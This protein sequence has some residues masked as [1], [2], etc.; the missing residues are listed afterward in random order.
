MKTLTNPR[1]SISS[2][3]EQNKLS[4]IIGNHSFVERLR[5]SFFST[6]ILALY[7][8]FLLSITLTQAAT[9][10][11][12]QNG[13]WGSSSTWDRNGVPDVNNWPNDKV[14]INHA[15]SGGGVTMN[16]SSS[17]ITINNGGSLTL[18]G[19][20]N[21]GSGQVHVKSGGALTA[22]NI[23]LNTTGSCDLSGT[24]TTT[25]HMDLDGVFT[26]SPTIIVGGR[27]LAGA[28]NY[29]QIFTNLTLTVSG[30][31]TV[32]NANLRWSS[33]SVTVGGNFVLMG[34]GDVDVP[35]GGTLDVSGTLSVNDLLSIDGPSG[36]GSGGVVSWGVG[37]VILSGNNLG[38]NKCPKPYNSPF[39]LKTCTQALGSDDT[40]PVITLLGDNPA[41]VLV[42]SSYT[43]AGATAL[44]ETDGD[45]T[46]SI[47]TANNVDVNTIGTY[48]VTYDVSDAAGNAAT[49]ITRTVNVIDDI[50][51]TITMLGNNPESVE[52]GYTYSDAGAS[53]SDNYDGDITADIITTNSVDVTAVGT[54]SVT[55][56]VDDASGNSANESR[57][58]TV[59]P[60]VTAPVLT[61][62]GNATENVEMGST[63]TDA[64]ATVSDLG[65]PSIGVSDDAA[66]VNTNIVG[67]YTVTY[68]ATDASGNEST[69]TR[70][71]IVGNNSLRELSINQDGWH[72]LSF[73]CESIAL[74]DVSGLIATT[75]YVLLYDE[76]SISSNISEHSDDAW[77]QVAAGDFAT[78][79]VSKGD[80]VAVY[81]RGETTISYT[82]AEPLTD[83]PVSLIN[84]CASDPECDPGTYD[85]CPAQ[86]WNL[87]GNPYDTIV[88]WDQLDVFGPGMANAIYFWDPANSR[89]AAYVNGASVN[90]GSPY[91]AKGQGFFVYSANNNS[92]E[93]VFADYMKSNQSSSFYRLAMSDEI[94]ISL[95]GTSNTVIRS[96][97]LATDEF[98]MEFDAFELNSPER[99]NLISTRHGNV[100]FS[101]NTMSNLTLEDINL[102]FNVITSGNHEISM[103]SVSGMDV[104][105]IDNHEDVV[106]DLSSSSYRFVTEEGMNTN[107]FKLRVV[108]TEEVSGVS[109]DNV[110]AISFI[111]NPATDNIRV[112]SSEYINQLCLYNVQGD[113]I[114][115]HSVNDRE[116]NLNI[117]NLSKG[118]YTIRVSSNSV[119][120]S[121]VIVK[122]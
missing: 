106:H 122:L 15:V 63:Y 7:C 75:G 22:Y 72:Y 74:S 13:P 116:Y 17:R 54:Y 65:D 29:N 44:D 101:V 86:G 73:S 92:N 77:T 85:V 39:D 94:S 112:V 21:V 1:L 14:I 38:L 83:V 62:L 110:K 19:T 93:L 98:D 11:S 34:S 91:I 117:S 3:T 16:G 99:T 121:E 37:N 25:N 45:V 64:G 53:V 88:D 46:G 57:T 108:K 18:T 79:T 35:E 36:P 78:T 103:S 8:F 52:L 105:L 2:F 107:R 104:F 58:V 50:S 119:T 95:D 23:W 115:I 109:P 33:G 27:L 42:S 60:D 26:G 59:I 10:T 28:Q 81:T 40:A 96:S 31:M 41:L 55:Y 120:M 90:G 68:T 114:S 87:V 76:S 43:D 102:A 61:L 56:S 9:F 32:Q 12:V 97:D 100:L 6:T 71:V 30:N 84:T 48:S 4:T 82:C 89:Y 118:V 49:T 51:P 47:V 24:I 80:A 5:N 67:N 66:N 111:P 69:V 113:L 20:L 70:T